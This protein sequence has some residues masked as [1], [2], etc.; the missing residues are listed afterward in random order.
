MICRTTVCVLTAVLTFFICLTVLTL[1]LLPGN[2]Q[3]GT[4]W[5]RQLECRGTSRPN[6]VWLSVHDHC[7][8][9]FQVA[10]KSD[11]TWRLCLSC[12]FLSSG[13]Q[14][15]SNHSDEAAAIVV[16]LLTR[17]CQLMWRCSA[18]YINFKETV[19]G[20]RDGA[21]LTDSTHPCLVALAAE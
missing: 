3:L 19:F 6:V 13:Q 17:H 7:G 14:A 9:A 2:S 1:Y 5:R 20:V 16:K 18:A 8:A 4:E 12:S 10:H 11:T 21:Q 15:Y